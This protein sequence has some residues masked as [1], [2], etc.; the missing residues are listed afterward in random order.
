[1]SLE[2]ENLKQVIAKAQASLAIQ[3]RAREQAKELESIESHRALTANSVEEKDR[4]YR[5][6]KETVQD[7]A[8]RTEED[9]RQEILRRLELR[10]AREI[11]ECRHRKLP[12]G[13]HE[14]FS[15]KERR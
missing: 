8:S 11:S 13:L 9:L 14:R 12:I 7:L 5:E 1:M 4:A 2:V 3:E 15:V 10:H 6:V